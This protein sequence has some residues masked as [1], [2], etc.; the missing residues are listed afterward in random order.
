M[1]SEL[2]EL[3]WALITP[4]A[5]RESL[6]KSYMEQNQYLRYVATSFGIPSHLVRR[7]T[8]VEAVYDLIVGQLVLGKSMQRQTLDWTAT[9]SAKNDYICLY[10]APEGIRVRDMSRTTRHQSLGVCPNW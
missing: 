7:R 9:G 6:Q 4:E 1:T 8:L 3:G 5:P 10:F 2:P